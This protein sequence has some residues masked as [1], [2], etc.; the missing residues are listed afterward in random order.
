MNESIC[1]CHRCGY[2]NVVSSVTDDLLDRIAR[3]AGA[4]WAVD[5]DTILSRS[6]RQRVVAARSAVCAVLRN[7]L[8]MPYADIGAAIGRDHT[9]VIHAVRRCDPDMMTQLA[10]ACADFLPAE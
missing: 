7:E 9:T 5:P 1:V 3:T 10:E 4:L 6:Q 2:E 8:G